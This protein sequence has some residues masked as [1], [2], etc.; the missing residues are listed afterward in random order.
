MVAVSNPHSHPSMHG[1][2]MQ[3]HALLPRRLGRLHILRRLAHVGRARRR[4]RRRAAGGGNGLLSTGG[5]TL[6][7]GQLSLGLL[8]CLIELGQWI[9]GL[10]GGGG[11]VIAPADGVDGGELDRVAH[12]LALDLQQR[13]A[14]TDDAC[15]LGSG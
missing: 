14:A 13:V 9:G 2:L 7:R 5:S 6:H 15:H 1:S 12:Q 3:G 10:G 11:C 4:R 8:E